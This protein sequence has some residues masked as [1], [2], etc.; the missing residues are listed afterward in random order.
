MIIKAC[1]DISQNAAE[2]TLR[3]IFIT[4]RSLSFSRLDAIQH[5]CNDVIICIICASLWEAAMVM[6]TIHGEEKYVEYE[7]NKLLFSYH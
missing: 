3:V 6:S 2:H 1:N 7:M 4:L 5:R